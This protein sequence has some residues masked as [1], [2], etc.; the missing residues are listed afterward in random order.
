MVNNSSKS[1]KGTSV[2]R[3][4]LSGSASSLSPQVGLISPSSDRILGQDLTRQEDVRDGARTPLGWKEAKR[5][6]D[7]KI[8]TEMPEFKK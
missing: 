2:T 1:G 4:D 7:S 3:E 6:A 8:I 5:A